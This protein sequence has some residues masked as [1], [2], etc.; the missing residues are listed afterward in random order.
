MFHPIF[1]VMKGSYALLIDLQKD[2]TIQIGKL[3]FLPFL[4]GHY[5]YIGSALNGLEQ[6]IQ[7]HL[8]EE[9]KIHWH[10]DYLLQHTHIIDVYYKRS[11]QREE[12]TIANVFHQ[13]V[14]HIPGFGCS[15]CSC[16]SHLFHG[17]ESDL[18]NTLESLQ[19][20]KAN[21]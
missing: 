3:G 10:I 19:M 18:K 7:R 4:K 15:D 5:V 16:P 17:S 9:K 20:K 8:R 12:C 21:A 1:V 13:Q 11:D 14:S 6:R 2:T